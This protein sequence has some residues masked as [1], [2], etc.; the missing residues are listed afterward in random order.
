LILPN[1]DLFLTL[2]SRP[3]QSPAAS[4]KR[5]HRK[6]PG[7]SVNCSVGGLRLGASDK[8]LAFVDRECTS[9]NR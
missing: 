5:P 1:R 2:I 3:P 7:L 6:R 9:S 8:V 4:F